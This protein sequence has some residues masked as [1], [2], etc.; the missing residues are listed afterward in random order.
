MA[1]WS[2]DVFHEL[3][4]GCPSPENGIIISKRFVL[5]SS[6]VSHICSMKVYFKFLF[7]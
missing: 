3:R 5:A 6:T 4:L 2:L 7:S 1:Y